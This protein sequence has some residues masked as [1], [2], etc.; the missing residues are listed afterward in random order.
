MKPINLCFLF[1]MHQPWYR[2]MRTG[3]YI[4]PWVRLHAMKGY[5][6][7]GVLASRFP[8]IRYTVNL[9]P[10]LVEQLLAYASGE[11]TD[12]WRELTHKDPEDMNQPERQFLLDHFFSVNR[13]LHMAPGTRYRQLL[14]K[15]NASAMHA[16]EDQAGVFD[17]GEYRDLQ[18]LFNLSWMGW[19]AM[20][21]YP[22]LVEMKERSRHFNRSDVVRILQ[23]QDELVRDVIPRYRENARNGNMEL[24]TSP[25]FHPILPLLVSTDTATRCQPE[26]PLPPSVS[27]PDHAFRQLDDARRAF[28]SWFDQPAAGL[29][30]SEGSVSPEVLELAARAGFD[31]F[32]SDQEVLMR[33]EPGRTDQICGI[34]RPWKFE[35]PAGSITGVFR[36]RDLSDM[37]GFRLYRESPEEAARQFCEAVH[38]AA[39]M[40]DGSDR[41]RLI[42]VILDGENPWEYY[43]DSGGPFLHEVMKRLSEDPEIQVVSVGEALKRVPSAPVAAPIHSG[44]WINSNFRIWIGH[45]E[46]NRAWRL[47]GDAGRALQDAVR[48]GKSDRAGLEMAVRSQ[49]IAEGSDW[50]WWYG[51]DFESDYLDRFDDLFRIHLRNVYYALNMETPDLL[52]EPIRT[53]DPG[54]LWVP[55]RVPVS[56]RLS[57]QRRNQMAWRGAGSYQCNRRGGAIFVGTSPVDRV[58]FGTDGDAA[59]FRIEWA[60]DHDVPDQVRLTFRNGETLRLTVDRGM[61]S[62]PVLEIRDG[63]NWRQSDIA[64]RVN[65]GEVLEMA[66]PINGLFREPAPSLSVVLDI[67]MTD[68]TPWRFPH[69]G[70]LDTGITGLQDMSQLWMLY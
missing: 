45:Q 9:V 54:F 36:N 37:I 23:I 31:W 15:R 59:F 33:T 25:Y 66:V 20:S 24:T 17:A 13:E 62:E 64:V 41:E 69:A 60:A 44:S 32:A 56:P 3:R 65:W 26:T 38:A 47:L 12:S 10:S 42:A 19:H 49:M 63:E 61:V 11:A 22:E 29:W 39:K 27:L 46:T 51:D 67:F 68:G 14:D 50:F 40:G 18:V 8:A 2:D 48:E 43:T 30:P 35:T 21:N 55:S 58:R 28:R 5:T 4:M 16:P 7:M 57:G 1:H 34:Q 52:N 53:G 6:D 70:A